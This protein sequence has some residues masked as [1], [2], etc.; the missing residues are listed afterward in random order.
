M[1]LARQFSYYVV[2]VA[3]L[4]FEVETATRDE[5]VEALADV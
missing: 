3:D 1:W 4:F 2:M 5:K